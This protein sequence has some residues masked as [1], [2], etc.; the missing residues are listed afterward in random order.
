MYKKYLLLVVLS[1]SL[2]QVQAAVQIESIVNRP[3]GI[4]KGLVVIA[5]AKKY[6]MRERL[7][8]ELAE[9]LASRGY[10]AVRF[11][12]AP[13]TLL[14]P[15]LE[16]H[17]ASRDIQNIVLS[18]QKY[19]GFSSQKTILISKSFS[20]KALDA[21][22]ILAKTHILLTPNCSVEAPFQKMYWNIL[23]RS[24]LSLRLII[25][26]DDPYC[27]VS[28]IRRSLS[29]LSKLHI[30]ETTVH[31]DHNFVVTNSSMQQ[32]FFGYQDQVINS[33]VQ[34]IKSIRSQNR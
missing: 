3:T 22:L 10:I 9:K 14:V 27:N 33:I 31:G 17:R 25:S 15:E 29:F 19:F 16:L 32:P 4:P 13:D 23:N 2:I 6:L 34:Q 26:N 5:P 11:N 8:S 21:S 28:E 24:E 18:A 12:W 1:L 7:F 20:T 30:L